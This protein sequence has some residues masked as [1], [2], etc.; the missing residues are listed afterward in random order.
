E[1]RVNE[2]QFELLGETVRAWPGEHVEFSIGSAFLVLWNAAADSYNIQPGCELTDQRGFRLL[3]YG[4]GAG[5]VVGEVCDPEQT[6]PCGFGYA[7]CYACGID[8]C[9]HVCTEFDPNS[10]ECPPPPP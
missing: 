6:D 1:R 4:R 10:G 9:E 3:T 7:C 5:P 8:G 2:L